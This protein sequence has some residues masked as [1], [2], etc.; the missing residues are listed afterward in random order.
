MLKKHIPQASLPQLDWDDDST[1]SLRRDHFY[2]LVFNNTIV[3][4][5]Y[6]RSRHF[7]WANARM[8]EIF[9]YED[10][11]LI[12]QSVRM[13]YSSDEEYEDV[14]RH[15]KR[16]GP[17]NVYTHERAMVKK[18]GEMLWCLISGRL[19]E[20]ND[21]SSPTVWVVQDI[22]LRK[23][24]EN[25]LKR[26]KLRLEHTVETRTQNLH[27]INETLRLEMD[28]RLDMQ[29]ALVES[30]EKYRALF[31][32]LPIGI[33]IT[34]D[35]GKTIEINSA[36]QKFIGA[37][38]SALLAQVL[39][40]PN[41]VVES[42]VNSCSLQQFIKE[43]T[44]ADG[45]RVYRG[46]M[47]WRSITGELKQ[48]LLI[49]NR[50]SSH[51]LGA[52]FAFEDVTERYRARERENAQQIALAHA[53]RVSM[54]GQ[55]ASS[56]AHEL[57]QPLN[58]CESYLA[59][60]RLRFGDD[61]ADRP[62]LQGALDHISRHLEQAGQVIRNVRRFVSNQEPEFESIDARELVKQT[63]VLLRMQLK[64]SGTVFE[65]E[66]KEKLPHV[67]A[68]WTEVQQ[69]IVNLIVN[70]IESMVNVPV[71]QRIV[72]IKICREGKGMLSIHV[73]DNGPGVA[74]ELIDQIFKPYFSTKKDGLGM[75]LMICRTIVESHRGAIRCVSSPGNGANFSFTLPVAK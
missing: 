62:E 47:V 5:S 17:A 30:R 18:N 57:G 32:H 13:L 37:S 11:E 28:R 31:R 61:L 9:G 15:F 65:I 27:R 8:A 54:M 56:L 23:Q 43:K 51:G 72:R 40:D 41:R 3:G 2:E 19:T 20:P 25:Q 10:G 29:A 59:G 60:I 73:S 35:S 49:A 44:P 36:M 53:M 6:M 69:V 33:L 64:A 26:A 55:F 21:P 34:D 46:H 58:A 70:A 74:P 42:E 52:V 63:L 7:V 12:G 50:L 68:H 71:A 45:R 24:A 22:S 39:D 75:G 38:S 66:A 14:G 16:F 1:T 4:I 67:Q 48:F